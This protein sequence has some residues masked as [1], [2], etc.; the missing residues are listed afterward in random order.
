M[1]QIVIV[2]KNP[3]ASPCG[4]LA[5]TRLLSLLLLFP[6]APSLPA[7]APERNGDFRISTEVD[8]VL[9]D[10]SV[11]DPKGGYVSGLKQEDF[12][13]YE[14][15]VLQKI[16]TFTSAD[17]PVAVGL[18]TDN[19]GSMQSKRASLI[20]AG[21]EFVRG[22][23]PEDQI[24]VINFDDDVRLGLPK[25]VPFTD[26]IN[27]LRSALSQG[28]PQGRTAL[29]DAIAA[30]LK[31]LDLGQR[32]KKALI[33]VSDGG[34]NFS[35]IKFSELMKMIQES[36]ATVYTVGLYDPDDPDRN[37]GVLRR[38]SK[39]SG[40]ECFLPE[41]FKEIVP[42][43]T[44]IAKDIRNRYTI[45]YIP[46]ADGA[47]KALRKIRVAANAPGHEKLIVRTRSSYVLPEHNGNAAK[48]A[49]HP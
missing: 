30:G 34:D 16:T 1:L 33:V 7:Q 11:K 17:V 48:D 28:L 6:I 42:I 13:V 31:H 25:S 40:G 49:P 21:L 36:P 23:N 2:R 45:G 14:D 37:P 35:S 29:Y 12:K 15:G 5:W 10:V 24:F 3:P 26:N 32:G 43:L 47:K 46:A 18:V 38:I 20:Q 9:L 27:L 22:S 19:S 41:N 4:R 44:K 39:T 8:L